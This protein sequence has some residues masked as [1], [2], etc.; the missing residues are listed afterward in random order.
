MPVFE[1]E[2]KDALGLALKTILVTA[3]LLWYLSSREK[4]VYLIDFATFEPP[5]SWKFT[6][7]QLLEMMKL[8]G[9]FTQESLDFQERMLK[10]SGCGPATAWPRGIS[11]CL[12]GIPRDSSAEAARRESEV[13]GAIISRISQMLVMHLQSIL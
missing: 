2:R 13:R 8:Q 5:E 9:C 7:E 10:Q 3:I 11:Q 4:P 1:F 6:P 12:D